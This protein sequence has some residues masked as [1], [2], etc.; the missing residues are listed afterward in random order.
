MNQAIAD[1]SP[2]FARPDTESNTDKLYDA[3]IRGD[4]A[5]V[6]RLKGNYVDEDGNFSQSKY[7]VAIRKA[8][9]EN[10]P[11]IKEAAEARFSDDF[12]G[13]K[14]IFLAIKGEGRFA[15]DNI[16]GAVNA[17]VSALEK[18]AGGSTADG[19]TETDNTETL[20]GIE[21]YYAAVVGNDQASARLIYEDLMAE[22]DAEGYLAHEAEA[23]I[24]TGFAT[25]V[26]KNY[27]AGEISR[28][29]AIQL[30]TDNTD[31]GESEVKKWDF[32]LEHGFSWG[33]R[34]RKYRL[35]QLSKRDLIS[36]VMD[37]EGENRATAEAYIDFLDLEMANEDI[38]ITANDAEGYFKYAK[39]AGIS[40]EVYLDYKNQASQCESDKDKNGKSVSGSKK[41]KVLAVINSLPISKAQ[42]D[43]LYIAEGWAESKLY[44]APWH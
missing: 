9:R 42:K 27:M 20:F 11:R 7:D 16:M 5:Y 41:T 34:V 38:D 6:S 23:A 8:L 14:E 13:Y 25:Q 43:A 40:I 28:A 32:E 33:N 24:A 29:R 2:A 44:E 15:F 37:I 1:A 17:E 21:H 36:A 3:I 12:A 4:T 26:G 19:T 35:G 31:K 22:K 39:P 30:L 18:T 10:D